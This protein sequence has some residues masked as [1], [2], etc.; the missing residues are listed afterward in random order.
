MLSFVRSPRRRVP[1]ARVRGASDPAARAGHVSRQA[2]PP[3]RALPA[4]RRRGQP[5]ARDRAEGLARSSARRSSSTTSRARAAT[6]APPRSRAPRPTATRCCRARTARTASTRRSTRSPASIAL[7]DF[8]PIARWTVIP[9]M[10]VVHP[11]RAGE[12]REGAD[13]LPQGESGQGLVRLGGQR[14]DV[15]P[16]RRAVQ[17]TLTGTDI[18]HVPYKGG[19]PALAGLLAG[20]VQMM[21]DLMVERVSATPRRASSGGSR[22]T[23]QQARA[24]ARPRCPTLDESGLAGLPDLAATR[25]RLRAGRHARADRRQAQRRVPAGAR[26]SAGA[27]QPR[28]RAARIPM[29]GPPD[30]LAQHV[31]AEYPMWIKLVKDS[32]AKVD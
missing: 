12:Q 24:D 26:G 16:G 13:R 6:S 22:V 21:I 23:T 7:K 28:R 15:A 5:G 31:A 27:R 20:D 3:D 10:L 29:P 19:G 30:D 1:R 11:S 14:H 32:G 2:D 18:V 9:A 4:G 25:R 17:A 8:V